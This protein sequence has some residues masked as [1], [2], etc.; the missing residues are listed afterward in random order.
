MTMSL[1]AHI[2]GVQASIRNEP[3]SAGHRWALFQLL[4]VTQQWDRAIQQ[5]QV[6]AQLSPQQAQVAQACR[7]LV[8]AE[9]WRA[10]V[11]SGEAQPGFVIEPPAWVG[12]LV[13]ALQLNAAGRTD[14]AD[15]VREA[16]LDAA[17]LTAGHSNTHAFDW[18]ADS[19]TRLGPVCELITA[20]R[21]RWLPFSDIAS[22]QIA[23]PAALIDLVWAPCSLMLVDGTTLRGFM[24]ARYPLLEDATY[25]ADSLE[26][27]QL[28]NATVWT[29]TGRSCVIA[30]G[31][32]TWTTGAGDI[33]MFE[34]DLCSF[35]ND[36][37]HAPGTREAMAALTGEEGANAKT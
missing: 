30:Q 1:A 19:D 20:G 18:I 15:R 26:A 25:D 7:D 3:A 2:D 14:D 24:P 23:R 29:E 34:L 35:A 5:L 32:R 12:R 4:C 36:A 9:R 28:G 22:W 13:E 37:E 10:K 21:Y 17:P 16:A 33:S 31:R 11:M 8:R 27:L 6:F